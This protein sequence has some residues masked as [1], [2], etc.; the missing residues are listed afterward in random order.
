MR[1]ESVP[2]GVIELSGSLAI[3]WNTGVAIVA[4][5]RKK[6]NGD[7]FVERMKSQ[8]QPKHKQG[9]TNSCDQSL[10]PFNQMTRQNVSVVFFLIFK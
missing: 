9:A 7:C 4:F 6:N 5:Y 3:T 2:L 10:R 1:N 8:S